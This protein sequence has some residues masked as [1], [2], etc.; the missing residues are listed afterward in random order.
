MLL[1]R[2]RS[3]ICV[4]YSPFISAYD[5]SIEY[6]FVRVTPFCSSSSN[7]RRSLNF[8]FN[9]SSLD[10]CGVGS[11]FASGSSG[12]LL[13]LPYPSQVRLS[14]SVFDVDEPSLIPPP[15]P[16]PPPL[17]PPPPPPPP[18][19]PSSDLLILNIPPKR[20]PPLLPAASAAAADVDDED[21]RLLKSL[22]SFSRSANSPKSISPLLPP[23]LRPE[24]PPLNLSFINNSIPPPKLLTVLLPPLLLPPPSVNVGIVSKSPKSITSAMMFVLQ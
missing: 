10:N 8:S 4:S 9:I 16:P 17:P 20:P 11:I 19:S 23:F 5:E 22:S 15:P 21:R 14:V 6:R 13:N 1:W 2:S 24:S 18:P 7:F 3:S 12:M